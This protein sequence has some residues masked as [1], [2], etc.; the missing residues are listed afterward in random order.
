MNVDTIRLR[1]LRVFA[2][3]GVLAE[4]QSA[5]QEFAIDVTIH[6]DLATAASTDDLADTIDYGTL[7][8]AIHDRVSSERWNLIERVAGRVAD[9]VLED[10]RVASVEVR[11]HKPAA[12]I[13][14]PF[15]DVVIEMRRSR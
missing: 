15:D 12:P 14:V 2:H 13:S 3:H 10:E 4:E 8:A 6:A 5:G 1:G 7:A 11:V 9:L